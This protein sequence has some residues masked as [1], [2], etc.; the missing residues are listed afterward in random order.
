LK[1]T[2]QFDYLKI[3][4]WL[5]WK[6]MRKKCIMPSKENITRNRPK[7][8]VANEILNFHEA[9][10]S[11]PILIHRFKK[12]K[13]TVILT[14][15]NKM[16]DLLRVSWNEGLE[17]LLEPFF[18]QRV[19]A[20]VKEA[21][22]DALFTHFLK[23]CDLEGYDTAGDYWLCV[24]KLK[25]EKTP[26]RDGVFTTIEFYDEVKKNAILKK[27]FINTSSASLL[28]MSR[29]IMGIFC[30][31]DPQAKYHEVMKKHRRMK[32]THKEF[33]EF[34]ILFFRLCAPDRQFLSNVWDNVLKIKKAMIRNSPR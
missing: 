10:L 20:K 33:D 32:I 2:F 22:V 18:Q 24:D 26:F 12:V 25:R 11:D 16:L 28:N 17:E 15:A 19:L 9:I 3:K 8:M 31:K 13:Q 21:E 6:E 34:I 4:D 29:Q 30:C 1:K 23:E 5:Y 14:I 27:R 7:Y